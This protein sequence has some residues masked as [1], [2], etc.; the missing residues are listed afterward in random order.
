LFE[1]NTAY[2]LGVEVGVASACFTWCCDLSCAVWC[3]GAK[4]GWRGS[5]RE[6]KEALVQIKYIVELCPVV[7]VPLRLWCVNAD[8]NSHLKQ[9][10][11]TRTNC[12]FSKCSIP[13]S[14]PVLFRKLPPPPPPFL[15]AF[16]CTS[17]SP[18]ARW[19]GASRAL[20]RLCVGGAVLQ[21]GEDS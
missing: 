4:F 7:C 5:G 21:G 20:G 8:F 9:L 6:T 2:D 18:T 17:L 19:R 11:D 15:S 13:I 10:T 12:Y 16:L 14:T 1:R 3:A